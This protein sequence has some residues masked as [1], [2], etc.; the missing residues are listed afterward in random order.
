MDLLS[1]QGK[2]RSKD[3]LKYRGE[4]VWGW[5]KNKWLGGAGMWLLA[6]V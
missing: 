2:K 4:W 3:W 6:L 5:E 1:I